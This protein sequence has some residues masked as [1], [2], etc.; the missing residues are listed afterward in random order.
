[1]TEARPVPGVACRDV[2]LTFDARIHPG[3]G[4]LNPETSEA[5]P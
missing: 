4:E 2:T 1:M 3:P 5:R